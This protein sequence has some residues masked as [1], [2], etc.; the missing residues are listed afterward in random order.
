MSALDSLSLTAIPPQDEA[1]RGAV[2]EFLMRAMQGVP[3]HVRAKS[4]SGYD[5]GFSREL[6]GIA[7][8]AAPTDLAAVLHCAAC[9][10]AHSL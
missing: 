5:S 4:W 1:L 10:R 8:E 3:A 9:V 7:A 2:R 6:K